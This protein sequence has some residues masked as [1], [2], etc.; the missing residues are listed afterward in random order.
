LRLDLFEQPAEK[1]KTAHLRRCHAWT[2]VAAYLEYVS[3]GP[4]RAA[5]HLDLFEQPG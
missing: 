5:L 4:S 1:L 3:L 2:L